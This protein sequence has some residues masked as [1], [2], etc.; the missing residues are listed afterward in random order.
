MD[1]YF[2]VAG[3]ACFVTFCIHTW[4]GGPAIA[5][6]LLLSRDMHDVPKYTNYYCWHLVTIT[7]FA[8]ALAFGWAAFEASAKDVG[9]FAYMLSV[10]FLVWN[11][12]LI[13][14]KKQAFL[15]MPQWLLFLMISLTATPAIF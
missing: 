13:V 14:W 15:Q 12:V 4:A 7:L 9:I 11:L 5:R 3:A 6:P 1:I 10:A 8:M 2:A